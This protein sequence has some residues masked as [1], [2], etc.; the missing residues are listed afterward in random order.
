MLVELNR[1]K[2]KWRFFGKQILHGKKY[3]V[4][5]FLKNSIVIHFNTIFQ[6]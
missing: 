4:R 1:V 3:S 6:T 5:N 2:H